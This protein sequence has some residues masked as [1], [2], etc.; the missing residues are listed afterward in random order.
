MGLL[1]EAA[2]MVLAWKRW[3][4]IAGAA[5]SRRGISCG[6]GCLSL[7]SSVGTFRLVPSLS[8]HL[9]LLG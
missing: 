4:S 6:S 1:R 2:G 7:L 3:H 8:Q 5:F 9:V